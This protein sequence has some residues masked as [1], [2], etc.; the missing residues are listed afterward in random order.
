MAF[1]DSDPKE[2]Q[3]WSYW[4]Q[5]DAFW[6]QPFDAVA[7]QDPERIIAERQAANQAMGAYLV[8]LVQ[9]TVAQVTAGAGGHDPVSRLLKLSP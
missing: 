2:L 3:R 7:V 6:N 9:K 8:A 4:N 5:M 1:A